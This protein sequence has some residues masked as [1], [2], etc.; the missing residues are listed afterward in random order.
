VF[1]GGLMEQVFGEHSK[2][3]PRNTGTVSPRIVVD[4]TPGGFP[5]VSGGPIRRSIHKMKFG[6]SPFWR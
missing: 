1:E 4:L 5:Q 6:V 3:I 2:S